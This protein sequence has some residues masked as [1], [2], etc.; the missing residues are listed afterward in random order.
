MS[1]VSSVLLVDEDE[2]VVQDVVCSLRL[3]EL[4]V[5]VAKTADQALVLALEHKPQL[6]LMFL[7]RTGSAAGVEVGLGRLFKQNPDL[8]DIP[9]LALCDGERLENFGPGRELFDGLLK[10]PV[11]FPAFTYDVQRYLGRRSTVVLPE[12]ELAPGA[13]AVAPATPTLSIEQKLRLIFRV[14]SRVLDLLAR[15]EEFAAAASAEAL[16]LLVKTTEQA[17]REVDAGEV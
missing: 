13:K 5:H 11:E 6:V 3:V 9:L 17:V 2:A 10:V 12:S 16:R 4:P 1:S 14:Q 7:S 15:N 8:K